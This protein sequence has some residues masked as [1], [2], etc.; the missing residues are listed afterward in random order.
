MGSERTVSYTDQFVDETLVGQ[1][2]EERGDEIHF[3]VQYNQGVNV[4]SR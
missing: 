4:G 2:G 1:L 3:A